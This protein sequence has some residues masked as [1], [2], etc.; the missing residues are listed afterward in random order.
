TRVID[1]AGDDIE[2]FVRDAK[3]PPLRTNDIWTRIQEKDLAL[4]ASL[5]R[6]ALI[7][8]CGLYKL[9][10]REN[11]FYPEVQVLRMQFGEAFTTMRFA[12]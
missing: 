9:D 6:D 7:E 11:F 4:P 1:A 8:V 12:T 3:A 5:F 10:D 2:D